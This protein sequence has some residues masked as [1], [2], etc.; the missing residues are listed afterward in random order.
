MASIQPGQC[1]STLVQHV[2]MV[3]RHVLLVHLHQAYVKQHVSDTQ[4]NGHVRYS[5]QQANCEV[6]STEKKD[7][8]DD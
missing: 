7:L 2:C 1:L 3:Q 5:L 8:Q 6:R 4:A